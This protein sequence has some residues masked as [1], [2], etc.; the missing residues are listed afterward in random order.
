MSCN[1]VATP[2]HERS[3][4]AV[5]PV[6]PL[7]KGVSPSAS[8]AAAA[9]A[10]ERPM[11][12]ADLKSVVSRG[13]DGQALDKIFDGDVSGATDGVGPVQRQELDTALQVVLS[14]LDPETANRRVEEFYSA[15]QNRLS[16]AQVQELL[17]VLLDPRTV[18]DESYT[19]RYSKA[20]VTDRIIESYFHS[21][22]KE[23]DPLTA[24]QLALWTLD[25]ATT[26]RRV[27]EY[28]FANR[29][30]LSGPQV[31]ELLA[32]LLNPRTVAGEPYSGEYSKEAV[33]AKITGDYRRTD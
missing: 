18:G 31:Q 7:E 17:S 25:P 33:E 23:A 16:W 15:N 30:R 27:E 3:Q 24:L 5:A 19:G 12:A 32:V 20:L 26:N 13:L 11:M 8:G 2:T 4:T 14:T 6:S 28:Y 9:G 22:I 29:N 10:A 1:A 21:M